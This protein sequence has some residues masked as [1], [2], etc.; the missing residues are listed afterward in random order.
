MAVVRTTGDPNEVGSKA[1]T[2]LYGAVYAYKFACKKQGADFAV[3]ALRARW[4]GAVLDADSNLVG[5]RSDWKAEWGIPIPD[6]TTALPQK[7]PE[8][9]VTIE[10]WDYGVVAEI[11]HEGP[12]STEPPT[13]QRLHEFIAELGY[14]IA[15]P[16]EEEYLTRPTA[17]VPK[18]IIRYA[19]RPVR[20]GRT[21]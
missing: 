8:V 7:S 11:L 6:G 4:S 16:H 9:E 15:G 14:E 21:D 12:Y 19:V 3:E 17:K 5:D 20:S 10:R 18:T 13:V 2:A 1:L